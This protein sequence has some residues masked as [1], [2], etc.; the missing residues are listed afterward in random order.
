MVEKPRFR[1]PA[2]SSRTAGAMGDPF[3]APGNGASSFEAAGQGRRLR[4][5]NPSR[6]HVNAALQRSGSTLVARARWLYEN[7][8]YAGNAVDE[9]TSAAIGDGIKPRP[10]IKNKALRSALIDLFWRWTEEADADGVT[11]FYGLQE[12]I[13]REVYLAG[14]GFVRIRARRPGDMMTVP[15]QLQFLPSEML[16]PT[17]NAV[18]VNGSYIRAGI[19]FDAIGRRAAYHFW[20]NHPGDDRPLNGSAL[21]DRVR[22]PAVDVMHV[23]DGRQGGQIRGVPRVARVLVKLFVLESYDDAELERKRS[24]AL[25]TAFLIGRGENPLGPVNVDSDGVELEPE[26]I[27]PMQPG[28]MV[29][30]GDD[31]DIKFSSPTEVGGSY[32]AFQYRNL[33]QICA[34]LGVPYAYVTGDVAKG[35]FSNVRTDIIRFRRRVSQ[36]QNN[37]MIFQACRPVWKRFVDLAVMGG[38][39]DIDDYA[40]NPTPYWAVD[41]LPPR[42]EWIDPAKDVKAE[43]EAVRAGFKTRTQV[44]AERGYDREDVDAEFADERGQNVDDLVFDTDAGAV[45]ANGSMVPTAVPASEADDEEDDE[46]PAKTTEEADA[47]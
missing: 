32:E 3:K 23:Y 42:M 11:D 39:V 7:N 38:F 31:K 5:F 24:A 2:G 22:V 36:W 13:A 18:L 43:R 35:N 25:F 21:R 47:D 33:T 14:E 1:V 12:K 26:P 29:D 46:A 17:F 4:G 27:A 40:V 10:K 16:D 19:E 44:V 20:R 34:G 45:S 30:L 28:A 9:F 37:V 8:G 41:W 15:F 6:N